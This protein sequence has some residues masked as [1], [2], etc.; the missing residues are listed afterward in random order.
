M[1]FVV[2]SV[3]VVCGVVVGVV[4]I[5]LLVDVMVVV[6]ASVD[7]VQLA[8]LLCPLFLQC[9]NDSSCLN[10]SAAARHTF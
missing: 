1:V 8:S 10:G 2:M 4:V 6:G 3:V 7:V 5:T 9:C